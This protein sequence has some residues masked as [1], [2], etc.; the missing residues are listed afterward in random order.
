M[1]NPSFPQFQVKIYTSEKK[2]TIIIITRKELYVR[3][4]CFNG[5]FMLFLLF[6]DCDNS[7]ISVD[8]SCPQHGWLQFLS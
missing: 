2:I 3:I 7:I 8:N 4:P 6:T 5:S 1:Y